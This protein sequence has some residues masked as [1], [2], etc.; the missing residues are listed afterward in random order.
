MKVSYYPGCTLKTKA[1]NLDETITG[2]LDKLGIDYFELDRWNC[3]G[4]VFPLQD[5]DLVHLIAPVRNLIRA[6]ER[7]SD[8]LMTVCSLCYNA[9]ARANLVMREDEEKRS[10]LNTFMEE[11]PDYNGE[12]EVLHLLSFLRDKVGWDKIREQVKTP[13]TGLKAAPYYGCLLQRPRE[14][15][16]D[17]ADTP[18]I[19]EE[20][21]AALGAESVDFPAAHEC[22]GSYQIVT[23]PDVAIEC[24]ASIIE[25]AS[26]K[27]ADI[28]VSSCPLCEYNLGLRQK[29]ILAKYPDRKPVPSVYFTQLLAVALGVTEE[30]CH[31]ELNMEEVRELLLERNFIPA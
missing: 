13:L 15:A 6:K 10:T 1:R 9:L 3:C 30:M 20:Y 11:E 7:G 2:S 25:S 29:D 12:V 19:F 22:C 28:L 26:S 31:F 17:T 8:V 27:E 16:I 21:L 14:I 18:E 4:A 23:H 24:S 5:D